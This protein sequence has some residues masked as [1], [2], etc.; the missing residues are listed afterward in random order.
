MI[1]SKSLKVKVLALGALIVILVAFQ[2][3]T[4]QFGSNQLVLSSNRVH[5]NSSEFVIVAD[6]IRHNDQNI[7][8]VKDDF[9]VQN[10]IVK[11]I[12]VLPNRFKIVVSP[13]NLNAPQKINVSVSKK[14]LATSSTRANSL[15]LSYVPAQK[16]KLSN[17]IIISNQ[18]S[19]P[20]PHRQSISFLKQK[21]HR[22]LGYGANIQKPS[23]T[24]PLQTIMQAL[25]DLNMK[26][27]KV[28]FGNPFKQKLGPIGFLDEKLSD[29]ELYDIVLD[30]M[31]DYM[32]KGKG[33]QLYDSLK[34]ADINVL[35]T[36][37]GRPANYQK[38]GKIIE[39]RLPDF[40][41]FYVAYLRSLEALDM[42]PDYQELQNEPNLGD[43][44][45][46]DAK[47]TPEQFAE[48]V[49][50]I[51]KGLKANGVKA[52]ITAAGTCNSLSVG[53]DFINAIKNK[54]VLSSLK[55]ITLHNYYVGNFPNNDGVPPADD[56][57]FNNELAPMSPPGIFQIAQK[58]GI[59]VIHSEFG[60]TN[61]KMK[62]IN[63]ELDAVNQTMELKA[64]IDLA[65]RGDS[66]SIVWMLFPNNSV[67]EGA[68]LETWSLL[69]NENNPKKAYWVFKALSQIPI[70]KDGIATH[71]L[72]T[73]LKNT[74]I[75]MRPSDNPNFPNGNPM[76][77]LG[78]VAF[79][80]QVDGQS[81]YYIV[82]SNPYGS[83]NHAANDNMAE[84]TLNVNEA[85]LLLENYTSFTEDSLINPELNPISQFSDCPLVL[86]MPSSTGIVL[87]AKER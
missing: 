27:V 79:H 81:N 73:D 52:N 11:S 78:Y 14:K 34:A 85:K 68:I 30:Q 51:D 37:Y 86:K 23:K 77:K 39:K 7:F 38:D 9:I 36:M 5:S 18:C 2:N 45:K 15:S 35:S 84:I 4:M 26:F 46:N 44:E 58:A 41:Q 82:I 12:D 31:R 6:F 80:Q 50:H 64:A 72:K 65:R 40:A 54:G 21:S 25:T 1:R 42:K 87:K 63:P 59:P 28:D 13:L 8:L 10:G 75:K 56:I 32:S 76:E 71:V 22:F 83:G 61:R 33:K 66:A 16:V 47:F 70:G 48:F 60:G 43:I 17:G 24:R 3:F 57:A 67:Q 49:K 62:E 69:D 29:Q 55:G 20:M 53:R 19:V 74:R